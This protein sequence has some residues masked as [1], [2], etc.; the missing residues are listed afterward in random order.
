MLENGE[1]V[2]SRCEARTEEEV[3][4]AESARTNPAVAVIVRLARTGCAVTLL[5]TDPIG[6]AA[7]V[8]RTTATVGIG[9]RRSAAGPAVRARPIPFTAELRCAPVDIAAD[10]IG[11]THA[12]VRALI[13]FRF[14]AQ[15]AAT[16]KVGIGAARVAHFAGAAGE[17]LI[18]SQRFATP[19][20]GAAFICR[21]RGF[22]TPR[23]ALS[24]C[25]DGTRGNRLRETVGSWVAICVRATELDCLEHCAATGAEKGRGAE[26]P[27]THSTA[28]RL[29]PTTPPRRGL[30]LLADGGASAALGSTSPPSQLRSPTCSVGRSRRRAVISAPALAS[31]D[32]GIRA[33]G[34]R[35]PRTPA[36][37]A[38]RFTATSGGS[39]ALGLI[40]LPSRRVRAALRV[41]PHRV[42]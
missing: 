35:G 8:R 10:S 15:E 5:G 25:A 16:A 38:A 32:C 41:R 33:S 37:L 4:A 34:A 21:A 36:T 30:A 2:L 17:A 20:R 11:L 7:G 6:P 39:T 13:S 27:R 40:P 9:R 24:R 29:R 14:T 23:A 22:G 18:A 31:S 12:I 28:V 42:S 1:A 3:R 19:V 26:R